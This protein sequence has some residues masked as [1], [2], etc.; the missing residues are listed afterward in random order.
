MPIDTE[1]RGTFPAAVD[2]SMRKTLVRCQKMA[3]W[4]HERGLV[5]V[6]EQRVHLVAGRAFAAGIC[7]VR[8]AFYGEGVSDPYDL[9]KAGLAAVRANYDYTGSMPQWCYKTVDR[10]ESALAF[11]LDKW[12]LADER[13]IPV[14]FHNGT[15]GIE[16]CESMPTPLQHPTTG[17]TIPFV[18][19]FDMLAQD[20]ETG[21]YWIVD[22]KTTGKMGDTWALQWA[23]DSQ[24]TGYCFVARRLLRLMGDKTA[25][26]AGAIIRGVSFLKTEHAGM[27]CM[28]YRQPW[29]LERWYY[30]M[31]RDMNGWIAAHRNGYHDGVYDHA[32]AL[33]NSPCEYSKLCKAHD[34]ER[35][36]DGNYNI[37]HYNPLNRED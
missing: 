19:N 30:Q 33:Y 35:L 26:V 34:P 36:I 20:R 8:R 4:K 2:N 15:L 16:L 18:A 3:Y 28:E 13:L 7:A 17:A 37:K 23:L 22:E 29:E 11:Y 9:L 12:P 24:L 6:G 21:M 14:R 32:C 27:E 10:V 31:M 1:V 5:P 25:E